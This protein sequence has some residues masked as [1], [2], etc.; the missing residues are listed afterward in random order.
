MQRRIWFVIDSN[1]VKNIKYSVTL[2]E[3]WSFEDLDF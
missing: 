1:I 3:N 2:L